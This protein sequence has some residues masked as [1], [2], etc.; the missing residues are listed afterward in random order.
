[1]VPVVHGID[2]IYSRNT[3]NVLK[4]LVDIVREQTSWTV[5]KSLFPTNGRSQALGNKASMS[6]RVNASRMVQDLPGKSLPGS[7]SLIDSGIRSSVKGVDHFWNSDIEW[8]L[9]ARRGD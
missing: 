6:E 7:T 4:K 9:K 5:V 8:E 3:W 1:M 2:A